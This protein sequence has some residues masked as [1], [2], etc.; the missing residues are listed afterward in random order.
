[1]S[2]CAPASSRVRISQAEPTVARASAPLS[3]TAWL[4]LA[5]LLALW[6]ILVPP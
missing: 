6:M 1:M 5:S 4:T 2:D 3:V